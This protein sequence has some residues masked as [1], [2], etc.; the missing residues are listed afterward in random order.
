MNEAIAVAVKPA[1]S[2][3]SS[4]G[5]FRWTLWLPVVAVAFGLR[6]IRARFV[7]PMTP[8]QARE[9]EKARQRRVR[10]ELRGLDAEPDSPKSKV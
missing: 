2:L 7:T 10:R 3:N 4:P 9:A 6:W 1:S 8:A 5:L